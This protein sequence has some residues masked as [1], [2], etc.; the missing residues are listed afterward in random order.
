MNVPRIFYSFFLLYLFSCSTPPEKPKERD[1]VEIPEQLDV[2]ISRNIKKNLEF[3]LANKGRLS[4]TVL[5]SM[6]SMVS[7][8][9]KKNDYE[10]LWSNHDK[11]KPE[12]DSLFSFIEQSKQY[13]LFPNDYHLRALQKIRSLVASDTTAGKDAALWS[14]G[15]L[16]FSDALFLLAKHLKQGRLQYDSVTLRKDTILPDSFFLNVFAA[17]KNSRDVAGTFRSLEPRHAGYDS[18]KA[19]LTLILPVTFNPFNC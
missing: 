18:L 5:L 16:I 17:I 9:Y 14:R 12:A 15:E 19:G 8:L 13:G 10:P 1:I 2:R 7:D 6:D 3:T 11:W 4:D